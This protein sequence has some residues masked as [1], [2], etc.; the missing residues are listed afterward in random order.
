MSNLRRVGR[1]AED[2]A[3]GH[4]L[5]LGYTIVTRRFKGAGGE[6]DLVALDG[7]TLVIVEVKSTRTAFRRAEAGLDDRKAR[8]L[9]AVADEYLHKFAL[10]DRHLRYDLIAIDRDGL[11]HHIDA[12]RPEA[13]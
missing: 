7:D 3:A 5:D 2:R 12:F 9:A 13:R 11:R 6:I 8:R 4:L 10:H 1:E